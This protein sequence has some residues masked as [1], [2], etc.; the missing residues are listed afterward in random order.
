M[1]RKT[2]SSCRQTF[3]YLL[4]IAATLVAARARANI[5]TFNNNGASFSL[6]T[7]A[8]GGLSVANNV[9][10]LTTPTQH[11][12]NSLFYNTPQTVTGFQAIFNYQVSGTGTRADGITFTL[13][14]DSRG[15]ATL[16]GQGNS[17]GYGVG[18]T[19]YPAT[20]ITNSVAVDFDVF[21]D[22]HSDTDL[23]TNGVIGPR[24]DVSSKINLDSGDMI[25]VVLTYNGST[26]TESLTDL[27]T[28]DTDTL[29]YVTNI[30]TDV[31]NHSTA[32]VG[33]TGGTGGNF[34]TQQISGF[35]YTVMAPTAPVPEPSVWE[36]LAVA[37]IVILLLRRRNR[38][39]GIGL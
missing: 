11:E 4:V 24:T 17:V 14:N 22:N 32:F 37:A 38:D 29:S 13:Q 34:S 28:N 6:N 15:A 7:T 9:A 21:K 35:S 8:T 16:G 23:F 5:S 18:T 3:G 25:H 12:A 10:T 33:F 36:V 30:V 2:L 26:L 27:T 20:A 19:A 1:L 39:S 31:G